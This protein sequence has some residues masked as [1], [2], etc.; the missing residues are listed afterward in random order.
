MVFLKNFYIDSE[1]SRID[2]EK[3]VLTSGKLRLF[4]TNFKMIKFSKSFEKIQFS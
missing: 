4:S 2:L 3:H 1:K